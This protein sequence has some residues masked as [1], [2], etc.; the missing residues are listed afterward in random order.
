MS[1][2]ALDPSAHRAA[3]LYIVLV[4][5]ITIV[6]LGIHKLPGQERPLPPSDAQGLD[7]VR[8]ILSAQNIYRSRYDQY[9]QLKELLKEKLLPQEL[10]DSKDSRFHYSIVVVEPKDTF[11]Y[12]QAQPL[13]K[14]VTNSHFFGNQDGLILR[15]HKAPI[16]VLKNSSTPVRKDVEEIGA[17][18]DR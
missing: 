12:V 4:L 16:K 17:G 9:G 18:S 13:D 1:S 7:T 2:E 3:I 15:S 14:A 10:E 5:L 8:A 11:F 6:S